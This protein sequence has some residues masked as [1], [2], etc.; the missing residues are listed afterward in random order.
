[1][2]SISPPM[3]GAGQGDYYL[4]LAQEDYYTKGGEPPGE[5]YGEGAEALGVG[6]QV[7]E[8]ELKNLLNGYSKDGTEKLVQNAGSEDRQSGWDLTF[9]APKSVSSLWA[10][11]DPETRKLIQESQEAAVKAGLNYIQEEAG[12]TR[13]GKGGQQIEDA[14]LTFATFEHGTSRAQDPQLHTHA[15]ALNIG[16][17]DDGTTGSIR[18]SDIF[19]QKMA[20][21]AVYRAELSYQLEQKLGLETER[22]KSFFQVSGVPKELNDEFS[23]RRKEIESELEDGGFSGAKASKVAAL[24]TRGKKG[25]IP[26][27]EL[28]E[29]WKEVGQKYEFGAEQAKELQGKAP[30][31]SKEKELETSLKDGTTQITDRDSYFT[32]QNLVRYTAENAQGRG[33][34]ANEV[35]NGVD[36]YLSTSPEIVHLGQRDGKT[37]YTT[38]EILAHEENILKTSN[39]RKGENL[40]V[41]S[42]SVEA[43]IAKRPT[44]LEEQKDAVR[45]ITQK[46]GATQIVTGFAGTGKSFMLEAAKEAYL[47]DG[48]KVYGAAPSGV[49]AKGLENETGIKSETIHR[50]LM[51]IERGNLTLD[52]KSVLIVDEAGMVSTKLM[53]RIV[54]ETKKSGAKLV[55][56]GAENQIQS[57]EA[58]GSLKALKEDLGHKELTTIRRQNEPWSRDAVKS[59]AEG[60]AQKALKSYAERGLVTVKDNPNDARDS[61]IESWKK[62]GVAKPRENIIIAS[63]N[64]D[65]AILNEKAQVARFSEKQ[66]KGDGYQLNGKSYFEGDRVLFT[67]NNKKLGVANGD[68]GTIT[69]IDKENKKFSVQL[70]S[71]SKAS[72]NVQSY[73][74][75]KLGYAITA[76]K[77]QGGTFQNSY[78][79]VGSSG[80]EDREISYVKASRAKNTTRFFMDK[81]VAG[82]GLK[83]ISKTMTKS[84]MKELATSAS[85]SMNQGQSRGVR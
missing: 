36:E 25:H 18:S 69:E 83:N 22:D 31:R 76:H 53:S 73:D 10:V 13:R 80:L 50:T 28:F 17:R 67:K 15:L 5:W 78:L 61:L 24:N 84:H 51:D 44:M 79:Y 74:N 4:E 12:I 77:S 40:I 75:I 43:A 66:L 55:L 2:L 39:A 71:G 37:Y 1:M 68:L 9:S 33:L 14:K 45:H 27:E 81:E 65:I 82:E 72:I 26:R 57:V 38:K 41:R 23:K 63:T 3:K 8:T 58:G 70:D 62:D 19:E 7:G 20:A 64:L 60:D 21:G 85:R 35:K 34:S 59:F 30:A 52:K 16:V 6:G 46:E 29:S 54:D 49:A 47:T 32:R 48:F 11:S 42:Q 56:V